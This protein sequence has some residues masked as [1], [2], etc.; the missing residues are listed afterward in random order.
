MAELK[1]LEELYKPSESVLLDYILPATVIF[2]FILTA[3]VLYI[4]VNL[5]LSTVNW[6]KSKCNPKYMFISGFI[7]KNMGDSILSS[8]YDN[9][10]S[11]VST[12][13]I[14]I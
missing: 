9:F 1:I 5:N 11:C 6:A 13:K 3:M 4:K 14:K 2:G 12:Y 8:I 7:K 10:V